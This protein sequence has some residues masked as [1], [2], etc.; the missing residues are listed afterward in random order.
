M[1][2]YYILSINQDAPESLRKE[3][4]ETT[5]VTPLSEAK[6]FSQLAIEIQGAKSDV[7]AKLDALDH[8][9][10]IVEERVGENN[11]MHIDHPA[12]FHVEPDFD[13]DAETE[14]I[15]EEELNSISKKHQSLNFN[16]ISVKEFENRR[17][18]II[19][20]GIDVR[21][22][23]VTNIAKRINFTGD[24]N[25]DSVGHGTV[26]A[27]ILNVQHPNCNLV[28]LKV[29]G[30][31]VLRET[32]IIQA[33]AE[34]TDPKHEIDAISMSLGLNPRNGYCPLC[35]AV[36]KTYHTGVPV[37]VSSGQLAKPKS[38]SV[39]PMCPARADEAIA[40]TA[41]SDE[42]TNDWFAEGDVL[43]KSDWT[44][45]FVD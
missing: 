2:S 4:A 33:L 24:N 39:P 14:R 35:E 1:D 31:G 19:D 30:D 38:D 7:I 43:A 3:V 25:F 9:E 16:N 6:I 36:N 11:T 12:K 23:Q 22:P 8:V 34:A 29:V 10:N 27:C 41:D 13:L 26:M 18:G 20:S 21:N 17:I 45:R 44:M 40:V 32:Y 28:D 5:G 37:T 15:V 42:Q